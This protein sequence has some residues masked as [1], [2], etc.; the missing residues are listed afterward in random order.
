MNDLVQGIFAGEQRALARAITAIENRSSGYRDLVSALH[1]RTGEAHV[2]GVTGPPGAGKSTLVNELTRAY[3]AKDQQVGIIAVDPASPFSGGAVL[4]DRIRMEAS[5]GDPGVFVRSMSARGALGGLSPATDDAVTAFDAFGIDVIIVETVGAG[6]S[7]IDVVRTA[8]T[9]AVLVPPGSG[10]VVQTMKAGILEIA[11]VFVVNKADR[12][13]V[14]RL[15]RDLHELIDAHG[16]ASRS[17]DDIDGDEWEPMI[18]ETVSTEGQGIDELATALSELWTF[19]E[20]TGRLETR[21]RERHAASLRTLLRADLG[22]FV[23]D[24][25]EAAGGIDDLAARVAR[26]QTSP[27]DVVDDLLAPFETCLDEARTADTDNE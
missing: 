26:G 19:L 24:R 14:D 13:G 16:M 3:R 10:D 22:E 21:R 20:T 8:D 17:T 4:G 15:V 23:E 11:D 27:Y 12:D 18:V 1:G 7:E 6:Q 2:I 25:I 9:V 5:L